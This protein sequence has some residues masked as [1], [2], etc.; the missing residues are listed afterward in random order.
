[1]IVRLLAIEN[2]YGKNNYGWKLYEKMQD[3]R[4]G[5]GFSIE[6]SKRFKE[7]IKSFEENGYDKSSCILTDS[8]IKL[9]DGSHRLA[10]AVY[11]GIQDVNIEINPINH[12]PDYK[13]EWFIE[14]DFSKAELELITNRFNEL[15]NS[16]FKNVSISCVLWAPAVKYFDEITD[17]ISALYKVTDI[18]DIEFSKDTYKRMVKAV[19]S[20]DDI[21]E[22]KIDKK[23]EYMKNSPPLKKLDF[24]ILQSIIRFFGSNSPITIQF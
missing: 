2:Y 19:Y 22:W 21:Q 6:A 7:L 13:I 14:N 4:N 23:I 9:L 10:A 24:S 8:S 12:N 3:A 5:A 20:I 1:M 16:I 15:K 11:Y 18:K 17:K